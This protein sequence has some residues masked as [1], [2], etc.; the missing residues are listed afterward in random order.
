MAEASGTSSTGGTSKGKE[1]QLH[2]KELGLTQIDGH[3]EDHPFVADVV[4]VHGL[5]GH[6]QR[7]WQSKSNPDSSIRARKRRRLFSRKGTEA[8]AHDDPKLF[9]PAD[10]LP[11]DHKDVRI[12]TFG[13]DS[14]V[15]K[16][17]MAPT[18]KNGIFQ[19]GNSFLRAVSRARVGCRQRP[20]VLVAHSLGG[21]V[22]K[23][24]LIEAQKQI[25][26]PDLL[27]INDSTHAIIFFGTPHR[28]SDLASWGLLLST[29]AKVA[30]FDTNEAVLRDLD[31]MSGSSK[32]EEM[33]LDFDDILQD[34]QRL[35]ELH[36]YSF[37]EEEGM[38]GTKL[39]GGKVVSNESSSLDSRKYGNDT[40]HANHMNMCRFSTKDDDGYE[41]FSAVLA[42][43]I[44]EIKTKQYEAK[45]AR[46]N[47]ILTGL[48]FAERRAREYQLQNFDTKQET[49]SWIWS[50]SSF[51][52][53]LSSQDG[54]YWIS[55]KPGSGKST[56]VEHLV[57]HDRTKLELQ[58]QNHMSWICLLFFFDF[59][60]GK[61]INNSFEGLLRSLLYQ[62]FKA[63]PQ[64][65]TLDPDDSKYDSFSSWPERRL[66][67]ALRTSLGKAKKGVCI[68]VD[69][70]DEYEGS[71]L[72]LIRFLKPLATSDNSQ[73]TS[74]KV[75]LSSRPEPIPSQFL[76]HL[77]NLSM[78]DHNASGIQSYCLST[79]EE[80]EPK[81]LEGLDI[82][83][84][85]H[86]I[87]ERAEG[88]FLWAR[89]ALEEI[90][91]GHCSGETPKEMLVRLDSTPQNLE[92]IYDRMFHRMDAPAKEEC[93]IMLR[94]VCFAKRSLG[95]QELLVATDVAMNKDVVVSERIRGDTD[96]AVASK[97][98]KTFTQR[99]RAKAVG[100][101]ELVKQVKQQTDGFDES[102]ITPKL[103]HKSV[104]TY[105]DRKGWQTLG[106]L[107]EETMIQHES[108]FIKTCSRYLHRLLRHSKLGKNTSR[109]VWEEWFDKNISYRISREVSQWNDSAGMYSFFNYAAGNVFEHAKSLERHG[110][111]SYP[112]LDSH[113]TEQFY[114]HVLKVNNW[115]QRS[116]IDVC[117]PCLRVPWKL[118]FED[119]DAICVASLHGLAS[120]CQSDLETRSQAPGQTFWERALSCALFGCFSPEFYRDDFRF[121]QI[122]TLA[123][124]NIT[125]V[126]QLH[127]ELAL[128]L[129]VGTWGSTPHVEVLKLVLQHESI[130]S[131]QLVD[132]DGQAVTLLWLLTQDDLH[133][134]S[135]EA[136][137][138]LIEGANRR[139]EDVRQRCGPEG[140]LVETLLKRSPTPQ[141]K[142][143]LRWLCEYYESMSWPFEYDTDEIEKIWPDK[144]SYSDNLF[145]EDSLP[146]FEDSA[147]VPSD[148]E[149][150][151]KRGSSPL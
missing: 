66:R 41:K 30:Q 13:Y 52:E 26:D 74:I 70:L 64:L 56:L 72:E 59:R 44:S 88:V 134:F 106:M 75:C 103:I 133:R 14:K 3:P 100:L 94:L 8:I 105:L 117:Q 2:V 101:L 53:W 115:E 119:F 84:V 24:A 71:L 110:V 86:T 142:E 141:R 21:L 93:M 123:L 87:A 20:I 39:F 79:L 45:N 80:L 67:D 109:I 69:G 118:L 83:Q 104:S 122:V 23:Q 40:I 143:K 63:M 129:L 116:T 60:R 35:R 85:S 120:Y 36:V 145:I 138:L 9:W 114:L 61:G 81:V 125:T 5:Q 19:H 107:Q 33:R 34:S 98:Y 151:I 99:L 78:S 82:L 6:P 38:T 42:K 55:G 144:E 29:I 149:S 96:S 28:G 27:D 16:A 136:F 97:V 31:P 57:H 10:I 7:T 77:P 43:Y 47:E 12:L 68:F 124:Q 139:E 50:S 17:F 131:L 73:D 4:F 147:D 148:E 132:R 48:D 92:E 150:V 108:F 128:K 121:P 126:Q 22:V 51:V 49:F 90:I 62:L 11:Q 18:S 89:F 91:Q 54:V 137:D 146:D 76:Q 25:H 102:F 113:L 46:N 15:T 130:K 95:W 112:L 65:N 32:L 127:L 111:S 37:Q 140:N 58:K 135:N 1:D